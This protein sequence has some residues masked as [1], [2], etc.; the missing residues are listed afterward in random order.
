MG[1]HKEQRRLKRE[2]NQLQLMIPVRVPLIS[3]LATPADMTNVYP[4][5]DPLP[6]PPA[7]LL[8][9]CCC[10]CCGLRLLHRPTG[11]RAGF[12]SAIG[13]S[14]NWDRRIS[15]PI[16]STQYRPARQKPEA[17]PTR[18]MAYM[19]MTAYPTERKRSSPPYTP[20]AFK[21]LLSFSP[22]SHSYYPPARLTRAII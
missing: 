14:G 13:L 16:H 10:C 22:C 2:G 1:I 18:Y 12:P 21:S 4:P 8:P 19:A 20:S 15:H 17:Y 6:P 11:D 5:F 9:A 7:V 3:A